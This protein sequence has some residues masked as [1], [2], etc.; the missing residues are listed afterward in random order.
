M[1]EC[2][3][4]AP[5]AVAGVLDVVA[6]GGLVDLWMELLLCPR[7]AVLAVLSG[8]AGHGVAPLVPCFDLW[9]GRRSAEKEKARGKSNGWIEIPKL[10]PIHNK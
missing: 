3:E 4:S 7:V 8:L 1:S 9:T 10:L 6:L 5:R 2:T